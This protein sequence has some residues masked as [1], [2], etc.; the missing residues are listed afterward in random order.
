MKLLLKL[1]KKNCD[2]SQ[3][4]HYSSFFT[5][6]TELSKVKPDTEVAT[7]SEDENGRA[8]IIITA[9]VNKS[10]ALG[11]QEFSK[12]RILIENKIDSSEG[13]NQCKKYYDYFE[14][15]GRDGYYNLYMYL[16]PQKTV[17]L[18]SK[19]FIQI[20]YQELLDSV[21]YPI[22]K[23]KTGHSDSALY[24]RE[25]INTITSIKT[26]NIL[27]MSDECKEQLKNLFNE[28]KAI[29]DA[30]IDIALSDNPIYSAERIKAALNDEYKINYRDSNKKPETV[31]GHS[32]LAV[33]IARYLA[34]QFD[35]ARLI[36]EFSEL[37]F[38]G[39]QEKYYLM[40]NDI[41]NGRFVKVK[42]P[43]ICKDGKIVL[44]SNQWGKTKVKA[45]LDKVSIYGITVE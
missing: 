13:V 42:D 16:A 43:I 8:D 6:Q 24:L 19:F 7:F 9:N 29:F 3:K 14:G 2:S 25:Y 40:A 35:Q 41:V 44:C 5:K 4:E 11:G 27:A 12:I 23:Y 31:K 10:I 28:N 18:S 45:L 30:F 21:L 33:A 17:E 34:E 1:A 20:T 15:D 22:A 36:K 26:S 39:S 38:E 32:K 37:S